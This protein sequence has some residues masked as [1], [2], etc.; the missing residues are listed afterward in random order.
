MNKQINPIVH[1]A[2]IVPKRKTKYKKIVLIKMLTKRTRPAVSTQIKTFPSRRIVSKIVA[3]KRKNYFI[4]INPR[5]VI[6]T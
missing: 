4:E 1:S 2:I 3:E 5:I 6:H